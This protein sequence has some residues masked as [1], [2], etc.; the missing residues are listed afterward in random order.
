MSRIGDQNHLFTTREGQP[1]LILFRIFPS[2]EEEEEEVVMV[3]MVV[4][5]WFIAPITQYN[6][7]NLAIRFVKPRK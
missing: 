5:W 2:E 3:V 6:S 1:F 7:M 4:W